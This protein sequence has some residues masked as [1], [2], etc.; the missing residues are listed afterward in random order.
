MEKVF[1]TGK[2]PDGK[3]QVTVLVDVE[4]RRKDFKFEALDS[5]SDKPPAGKDDEEWKD[6]DQLLI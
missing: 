1:L 6:I 4:R 2:T 5:P 3:W